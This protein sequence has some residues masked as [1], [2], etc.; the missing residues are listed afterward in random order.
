MES[1]KAM[2]VGGRL[3]VEMRFGR[4]ADM[5]QSSPLFSLQNF[6]PLCS[7]WTTDWPQNIPSLPG[8]MTVVRLSDGYA[9]LS[10]AAGILN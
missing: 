2:K 5:Y 6:E 8:L 1:L 9:L 4:E 7:A 3:V 10:K